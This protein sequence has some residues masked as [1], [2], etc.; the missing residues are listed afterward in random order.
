MTLP[1]PSGSVMLGIG[2]REIVGRNGVGDSAPFHIATGEKVG[3]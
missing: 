1:H 3:R 2:R